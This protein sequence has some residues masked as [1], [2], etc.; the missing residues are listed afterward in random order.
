MNPS[1]GLSE[2]PPR[3]STSERAPSDI[4][5][6]RKARRRAGAQGPLPGVRVLNLRARGFPL[7]AQHPERCAQRPLPCGPLAELRA[8]RP[9]PCV[10]LPKLRAQRPR[11]RR[12]KHRTLARNGWQLAREAGGGAREGLGVV[13]VARNLRGPRFRTLRLGVFCSRTGLPGWRAEVGGLR[14]R[15]GPLRSG[16]VRPSA[17]VRALRGGRHG[18]A[19]DGPGTS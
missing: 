15:S 8:Q 19:G 2:T 9:A 4:A 10:L 6:V 18:G 12:G 16:R 7:R 3:R 1:L 14:A 13:T 5:Q 11:P 17:R